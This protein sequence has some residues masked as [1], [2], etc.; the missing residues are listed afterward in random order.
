[1]DALDPGTTILVLSHLRYDYVFQRPQQ[2]MCRLARRHRVVFVQEPVRTD[3]PPRLRAWQPTVNVHVLEPQTPLAAP[4]FHDDQLPTLRE[5]LEPEFAKLERPVLW[6]YTPMALPLVANVAARKVV[7]DCMDELAAFRFA[8]RQLPQREAALLR[9]ADVVFTGGRSLYRAK[10][11][12][13]P[14]V[15]C[16]PSGV[17]ARH[18]ASR[19]DWT[20]PWPALDHP[21]IGYYGVIDERID[22][23]LLDRLACERP[24]W[25]W[26]MVGPVTKVDPATL[27]RRPNLHWVG[28]QAFESLPRLAA[29]WDVCMMPFALNEATRHISPTKTLEY[30]AVGKPIVST[31]IR[32]V[33]EPYGHVV[34][35][36]DDAARFI[37]ACEDVLAESET[38]RARRAREMRDLAEDSCWDV[39][40]SAMESIVFGPAGPAAETAEQRPE[41]TIALDAAGDAIVEVASGARVLA[42]EV[43]A[44]RLRLADGSMLRYDTLVADVPL[45]A[46]VDLLGAGA[47]RGVH[48]AAAALRTH[49]AREAA[50]D[51]EHADRFSGQAVRIHNWLHA[52]DIRS[53][54]PRAAAATGSIQPSSP[55]EARGGRM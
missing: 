8:P 37:E 31:G 25:H 29:A 16:F 9:R 55:V 41:V 49:H 42:V 30:M 38:R 27:P 47:P 54:L 36:A 46:L 35:I 19:P 7:Y 32:D 52:V 6:F 5:L 43:P 51:G 45:P 2:L 20:D 21:R 22:Y 50:V 13:H 48:D 53:S 28:Q 14:D 44:R 11:D 26:F 24:D 34:R 39:T 4:G 12:R 17:D 3:G 15:W 1:M 33:A 23:A 40:A 18:F 10:R